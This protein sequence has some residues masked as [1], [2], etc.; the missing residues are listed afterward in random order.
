MFEAQLIIVG[1]RSID[2]F[3][4]FD[5]F[6]FTFFIEV[7]VTRFILSTF[8]ILGFCHSV[9]NTL[10]NLFANRFGKSCKPN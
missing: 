9:G 2:I 7:S 10:N 6:F 3:F 1:Q 4:F 5:F 8:E